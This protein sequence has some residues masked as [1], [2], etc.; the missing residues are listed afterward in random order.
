[1]Q[2]SIVRIN[3]R[4]HLSCRI[5]VPPAF[6]LGVLE[7]AQLYVVVISGQFLKVCKK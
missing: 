7:Q 1:L 6:Y 4:S 3:D 5:E 2:E